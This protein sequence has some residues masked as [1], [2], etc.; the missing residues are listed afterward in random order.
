MGARSSSPAGPAGRAA[1]PELS[2]MP[3]A[4]E[5]GRRALSPQEVAMTYLCICLA[6]RMVVRE[7]GMSLARSRQHRLATTRC[8]GL[9][10]DGM[11]TALTSVIA[12]RS[13]RRL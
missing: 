4:K 6:L 7:G 12:G 13:R 5:R 3:A 11:A 10:G 1:G 2:Q 8:R 9:G